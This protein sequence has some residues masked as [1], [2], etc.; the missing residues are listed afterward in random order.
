MNTSIKT[1]SVRRPITVFMLFSIFILWG[2][3]SFFKI[4]VELRPNTDFTN[5]SIILNIRGGMAPEEV[6]KLITIP[7]EE[8]MSKTPELKSIRST[9]KEGRSTIVLSFMSGTDMD[10]ASFD[11]SDRFERIKNDL[12]S[13]AERPVIAK[14]EQNDLPV[15]ILALSS[16]S[17]SEEDLRQSASTLIKPGLQRI[18][19][20]ANVEITGGREKKIVIEVD[21]D[22]LVARGSS[23]KSVISAI[24]KNNLNILAGDIQEQGKVLLIR[25]EAL[26]KNLEEIKNTIIESQGNMDIIRVKDIA[27]VSYQ[28]MDNKSFARINGRSIV[29]LYI[30]KES[31]ANTVNVCSKIE[32]EIENLKGK[33]ATEIDLSIID[34]QAR[35]INEVIAKV[36]SALLIGGVLAILVLFFFLRDIL[37]TVIIGISI[38]VSVIITI[39]MMY[40]SGI[41]INI[42]SLSG[43]ALGIGMLVDNSIV[44]LENISKKFEVMKD[45]KKAII[46]GTFDVFGALVASTASTLV[47]FLPVFLLILKLK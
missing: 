20:V 3:I 13:E 37:I 24:S 23:I 21:E 28:Y 39:G 36:E 4:P 34:N 22:R 47:V 19:G 31:E 40:F 2:I 17:L 43:L 44:V 5:I 25:T 30:Q 16:D 33:L 14:Y 8:V 7:V 12:P 18:K 9:S 35:F 46:E 11:I 26:F 27:D 38:P 42:M 45:R 1:F 10:A 29:S 32:K 15:L 6:E 41:S